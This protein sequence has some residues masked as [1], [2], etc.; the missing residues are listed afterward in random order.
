MRTSTT[1]QGRPAHLTPGQRRELLGLIEA[2]PLASCP[3]IAALFE[4]STGRAI[5]KVT[6]RRAWIRGYRPAGPGDLSREGGAP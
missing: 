5:T 2:Y 1:T 3:A 4:A 6:V